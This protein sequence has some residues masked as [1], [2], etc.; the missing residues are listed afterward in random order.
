MPPPPTILCVDDEANILSS[1]RRLFRPAGYRVLVAESGAAGLEMLEAEQGAVDL[2]IS[3]MRMPAMDGAHFLAE[4]RQRWP[5]I[6]RILLTG[7]ADIESTIAAINE[8]QIYRYISKPWNDGEVLLTVREALERQALLHEK[9]RLEALTARQNEELKILNAGLE[10]K[11]RERTEEL[12]LAHERLKRSFFTSIQVFANLI[13]LRGGSMAGHSRRV[14]DLARKIAAGLGLDGRQC[15]DVFLAGLLHD[16]GKIGL[17]DALLAKP[18][19]KMS[20]EELGVWR[21]HPAKG[22]QALMAL[23]ELRGAAHLIRSHHERFDGQGYPDGLAGMAIPQGARI[24][25]LANEYDGHLQG[26]LT[27][28]RLNEDDA[29]QA[30]VQGRGKRYDPAVVDAFLSIVGAP[31]EPPADEIAVT[32]ADLKPGMF[33]ARDLISPEG[34]LLLATDYMLDDK[35]IRQIRDYE[36]SEGGRLILYVRNRRA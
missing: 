22:E 9:A 33:L 25:A 35:L 3:D 14:A 11:V 18:P 7:Y 26:T 5:G 19:A 15:N 20:G 32:P 13:E 27:G 31:P 6:L 17:P 4:V 21:K 2:V 34:V 10:E 16:I 1:L 8:G 28:K 29:K 36:R 24:L 30:I 23:E 12:R